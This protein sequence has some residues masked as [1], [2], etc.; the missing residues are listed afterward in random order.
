LPEYCLECDVL[1]LCH[2]GCPKDR[3]LVSPRGEMGL[4][5]L[6][7]GYKMF[8]RRTSSFREQLKLQE[9]NRK[10]ASRSAG[11]GRN[12][13]CPCGSGRKYKHCCLRNA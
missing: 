8:F 3:I 12:H 1:D 4:N 6:C 2:G 13:P 9:E 5:Y 11:V 10:V 7:E